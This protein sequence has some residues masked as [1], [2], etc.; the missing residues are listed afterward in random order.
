MA[1]YKKPPR[2]NGWE[3]PGLFDDC[4]VPPAPEIK[5]PE[6]NPRVRLKKKLDKPDVPPPGVT[7]LDPL[8]PVTEVQQIRFMSFGSGSSGNCAYLGDSRCGML[9]DAGV[10]PR[11]IESELLHHG[12]DMSRVGGILLTHDHGD[13]VRY[14]YN[15]VRRHRHIRIYCTPKALNGMMTRHRLSGRIRDY[16]QPFWKEMPFHLGNF[17]VTAFETSHDGIDNCGFFILAGGIKFVVATDMGIVTERADHYIRMANHLMIESNYDADMLRDGR[18]PDY[19]KARIRSDRGH[20]DNAE[21][22][23]YLASIRTPGLRTV[24]LCHL[25]HDNNTPQLARETAVNALQS[26]GLTVGDLSDA[27]GQRGADIQVFALPRY[28]TTPMFVLR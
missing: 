9:I 13:H 23:R 16:H 6:T 2:G 21:T 15:I 12:I 8:K 24:F 4:L 17:T 26:L 14:A 18:Y 27:P 3:G 5:Q 22:A 28:D 19:L 7:P 20:M 10:E 11:K 25:S 1:R